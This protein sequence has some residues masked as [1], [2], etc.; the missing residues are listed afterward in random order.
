MV[1][2]YFIV[3][4]LIGCHLF[5]AT[6]QATQTKQQLTNQ[7]L[8]YFD[9]LI[10]HNI[11]HAHNLEHV[12]KNAELINPLFQS[13]ADEN[14]QVLV[15]YKQ[16]NHILGRVNGLVDIK[17]VHDWAQK[18]L[19]A[20]AENNR[21]KEEVFKDTQGIYCPMRFVPLPA[22][23][24]TS[25][26]D[27]QQFVIEP[28]TEIQDAL[29][30]QLWM[31]HMMRS[32]PVDVREFDDPIT[33]VTYQ[34]VQRFI[35]EMNNMDGQYDYFLP[36]VN[37]YDA[38]LKETLGPDWM[39][40]V[41]KGEGIHKV[42]GV[43][44]GTFIEHNKRRIW[45]LVPPVWQYTRDKISL[46][47][48]SISLVFGLP[49][50][51]QET[52]TSLES[53][54]R[55]ISIHHS[56]DC[57]GFRLARRRK[58]ISLYS[59]K[60]LPVVINWKKVHPDDLKQW[61]PQPSGEFSVTSN[62]IYSL[63]SAVWM[64]HLELVELLLQCGASPLEPEI[65]SGLDL[66]ATVLVVAMKKG[67][68]DILKRFI[69]Y[70]GSLKDASFKTPLH[71]LARLHLK[72]APWD[73]DLAEIIDVLLKHG[74][75][76]NAQDKDGMTPLLYALDKE[77]TELASLLIDRGADIHLASNVGRNALM[78][79]CAKHSQMIPL[80]LENKAEVNKVDFWGNTA[81]HILVKWIEY[82]VDSAGIKLL[83]DAGVPINATNMDGKTALHHAL[84][85]ERIKI[86]SIKLLLDQ[87]ASADIKDNNGLTP[88]QRVEAL[89]I[90]QWSSIALKQ[91]KPIF[92]ELLKSH[93]Q[94]NE[95]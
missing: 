46:G 64:N 7:L 67:Y 61:I 45:G 8:S 71:E 56:N 79:A 20:L 73:S 78:Y 65:R 30:T 55:P 36:S 58:V 83:L 41:V 26:L 93:K 1:K 19:V 69:Y 38:L 24:Y 37:E 86:D 87:G 28:G 88:L 34:E 75:D 90:L 95:L 48:V 39:L 76:I 50:D 40:H 22:G 10:E 3:L 63:S 25:A 92:L 6:M 23:T 31:H 80:L 27:N 59:D 5:V 17:D 49:H 9:N 82:G 16:I 74:L 44:S 4:L 15:H 85:N 68:T 60:E 35:E 72:V 89:G 53:F 29:V 70:G 91:K 32:N 14:H 47:D 57:I 2:K 33:Y 21:I 52:P 62:K 66:P 81:L 43:M 12:V 11:L 13:E 18:N 84:Q 77:D 94:R 54:L 42:G 51:V